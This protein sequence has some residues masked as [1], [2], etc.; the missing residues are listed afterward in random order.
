[1]PNVKVRATLVPYRHFVGG[2]GLGEVAA[3]EEAREVKEGDD[4]GSRAGG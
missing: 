2:G 3:E 4:G 1:M